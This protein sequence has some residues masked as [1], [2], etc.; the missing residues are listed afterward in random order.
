[1][2]VLLR[3]FLQDVATLGS[4]GSC[5]NLMMMMTTSICRLGWYYC[6]RDGGRDFVDERINSFL[7]RGGS[8]GCLFH[9]S[10]GLSRMMG[11]M[12]WLILLVARN[13]LSHLSD[14][15]FLLTTAI[16]ELLR[17]GLEHSNKVSKSLANGTVLFLRC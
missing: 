17:E 5:L 1:M 4:P 11:Y 10:R 2:S 13:H 9:D 3:L 15:T 8:C 16:F 6:M 14:T 7:H 12:L